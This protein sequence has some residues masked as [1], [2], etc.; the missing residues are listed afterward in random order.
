MRLIACAT[1]LLTFQTSTV[2]SEFQTS[3]RGDV[4]AGIADRADATPKA[5]SM[6][7]ARGFDLQP[8]KA[9]TQASASNTPKRNSVFMKISRY[10]IPSVAARRRSAVRSDRTAW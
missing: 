3:I 2:R 8:G 5:E 10:L 4:A 1:A 6:A 9:N 7:I